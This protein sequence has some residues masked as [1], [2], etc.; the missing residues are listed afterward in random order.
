MLAGV[1]TMVG[2]VDFTDGWQLVKPVICW[3]AATGDQE[4]WALAIALATD[5][6]LGQ[7]KVIAGGVVHKHSLV[8]ML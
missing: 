5:G 8:F 3:R 6:Q 2:G 7:D 4:P 1:K